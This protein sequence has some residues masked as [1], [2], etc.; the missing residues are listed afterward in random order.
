MS[1]S[2]SQMRSKIRIRVAD[3]ASS[4]G[5][6]DSTINSIVNDRVL[7]LTGWMQKLKPDRWRSTT[8]YTGDT[9]ATDTEKELYALPSDFRTFERLDKRTGSSPN[10]TYWPLERVEG[11]TQDEYRFDGIRNPFPGNSTY[12]GY[13]TV[14]IRSG[15]LRIV[16]APTTADTFRLTYLRN[17]AT[18]S[19]DGTALDIPDEFAEVIAL[20]ATVFLL[21]TLGDPLTQVWQRELDNAL[22]VA[23]QE[24]SNSSRDHSFG[25][26]RMD[27][28]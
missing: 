27:W 23:S 17:P 25:P 9:D 14:S 20:S 22:S 24:A 15:S 1:V 12:D 3:T 19:V 8:T 2:L 18:V 5:F 6:S 7:T 4:T 26:L 21:N 28:C 16:P 10:Y 13:R 11:S